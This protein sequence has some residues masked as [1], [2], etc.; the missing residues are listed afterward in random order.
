MTT[1]TL[2]HARGQQRNE[3][4]ELLQLFF[5]AELMD[6]S[7]TVY[8]VSPWLRDIDLFDNTTGAFTALLPDAPRRMLRLLDV[9]RRLLTLGKRITLV[10]R[11]PRDDGGVGFALEALASLLER[12]AQVKVFEN[13]VLHTKALLGARAALLGSMNVTHAGLEKNLE[14]LHFTT[15]EETI[16]RLRMEFARDYG[17]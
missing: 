15:D 6:P 13:E 12:S 11:V 7:D 14:L 1:R 4:R 5:A 3:A 8:L 9:M 17:W 10:I 16:G 2:Q